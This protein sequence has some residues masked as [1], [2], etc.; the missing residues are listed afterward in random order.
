MLKDFMVYASI[1]ENICE[2]IGNKNFTKIHKEMLLNEIKKRHPQFN[3]QTTICLIDDIRKTI[4]LANMFTQKQLS[5]I[6][7]KN[8]SGLMN[9]LRRIYYAV[10]N[11]SIDVFSEGEGYE[12]I[13]QHIINFFEYEIMLQ[14][15][16]FF[17]FPNAAVTF[18]VGY[19]A[20]NDT[21]F[22]KNN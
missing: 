8:N 18:Y 1:I 11:Y 10:L 3:E 6:D 7:I 22:I 13:K 21:L 4:R 16:D 12:F 5:I 19:D 2:K 14:Q 17:N 20:Y 9:Y 15:I